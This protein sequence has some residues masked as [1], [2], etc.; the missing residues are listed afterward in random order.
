MQCAHVQQAA[1]AVVAADLHQ[2][3]R[4]LDMHG[5]KRA[6]TVFVQ[7]ADQVDHGILTGDLLRQGDVVHDVAF[8]HVN[9]RQQDQV[10]AGFA[11]AREHLYAVTRGIKPVH[12]RAADES[13]AAGH[14]DSL[15]THLYHSLR[16]S[17][18]ASCTSSTA[19]AS[20]ALPG[21]TP[22]RCFSVCAGAPSRCA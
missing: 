22:S 13:R 8:D 10:L 21:T 9:T 12:E 20:E 17:H 19:P 5:I 7:D 6:S 16:H 11:P 18:A 2:S 14:A 4:Q 1:Y 15:N 3:S